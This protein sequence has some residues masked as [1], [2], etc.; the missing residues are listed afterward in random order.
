MQ[1]S[2]RWIENPTFLA[3]SDSGHSVTIDGPESECGRNT[4]FRPMEMILMGIEGCTSFD[5]IKI[6]KKAR[7]L[8]R[9]VS[10]ASRQRE[11]VTHL[12]FLQIFTHIF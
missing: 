11:A 8:L 6:L 10:R 5:V 2:I 7:K 1:A 4:V 12:V 3:E 9:V